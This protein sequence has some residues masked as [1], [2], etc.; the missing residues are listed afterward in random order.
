MSH[1]NVEMAQRA[2]D[3]INRLD[4]DACYEC[5]TPDVE[6]VSTLFDLEGGSYRGR[7]GIE[8]LLGNI[9]D[10]FEEYRVVADEVRDLGDRVLM[11]ARVEG[12]G[13][14][15][16]VKVDTPYGTISDFRGGKISR[17]RTYLDH[18]E[19]LRA[20]GLSE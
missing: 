12:R 5:V 6:V 4:V 17:I 14:G 16:G 18:G 1:E 7:E 11:L 2:L 3:A 20:A 9:G 19:T 15:S 10:T 8:T 13:R